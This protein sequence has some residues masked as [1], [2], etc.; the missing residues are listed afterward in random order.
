MGGWWVGVVGWGGVV[1]LCG[2]DCQ[3]RGVGGMGWGGCE[4]VRGLSSGAVAWWR[5]AD[6][7]GND[8][9]FEYVAAGTSA[10]PS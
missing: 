9:L 1:E 10:L 8:K 6:G 7:N 4:R 5:G 2:V 3:W